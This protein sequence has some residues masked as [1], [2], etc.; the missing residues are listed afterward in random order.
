[1]SLT[2]IRP[3]QGPVNR[4]GLLLLLMAL[5]GTAGAHRLDAAGDFDTANAP[6]VILILTDDQGY[7][8]MSCHGNPWLETP[9]IDRLCAQSVRLEDYHVDPV[10][11]PTRA[12]LMTGRYCTRV[13]AW[14]VTQ[15]RQML[16]PDEVTMAQVFAASGY[17]TG[18]FGK[19]H[20]GDEYPF[21]PRFR[22][23]QDVVC[24][25]AGGPDEI[26]NPATNDFFDDTYLKNGVAKKFNGYCTDVW[27]DET[28][29]FIN[30]R[31]EKQA[32]SE[33]PFFIY[34]PTNAMHGPHHVDEKYSD[35]FT[36]A[37]HGETRA[38][39][40]GQI[41]NFDENLGRLLDR[42]HDDGLERDTI[43]IFMSDNGTGGG[44]N[45]K[46]GDGYNAA[47]RG[48]KGTVYEG[49]HRVPCFVR[50]PATLPSGRAVHQLTCH[51]DWMPTLI[52]LCGLKAPRDVKF[53]GQSMAALLRGSAQENELEESWQQRTVFIERQSDQIRP[54]ALEPL[55]RKRKVPF[56]VLTP[57]WRMVGN[58]LYDAVN[59]PSQDKDVAAKHPEVVSQL[60][61]AY[62]EHYDD[63]ME[64]GGS[65][66][67]FPVDISAKR[68]TLLTVRDWHPLVGR[69]I[70]R[71]QQL[72]DESLLINGW[73]PVE[74]TQGGRFEIRL[75][76][77]PRDAGKPIFADVARLKIGAIEMETNLTSN[78]EHATFEVEL[79]AGDA[80]LQTWFTD[81]NTGNSRGA[82]FVEITPRP[83]HDN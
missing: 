61:D 6:N 25:R 31:T 55:G 35:P 75:S 33:K 10:C 29:R 19:W 78:Q 52:E 43:V 57:K 32:D 38:K 59:D 68:P 48:R 18:M 16:A 27:F 12:A 5:C 15:G 2:N 44:F 7:G 81:T 82:Y 14:S 54:A 50:W 4:S 77:H 56:A 62:R 53:D 30:T 72:S 67:R 13:G 63:V 9:N 1:M 80:R 34:L 70:W 41:I 71:Q 65:E 46:P 22:G 64:H 49:G 83:S 26:G 47:M 36:A 69:V 23:F 74:V 8:D 73:W 66:V 20:L 21:A 51:R 45:G 24:H 76:R 60:Y 58:E 42:L 37:G 17:R 11:T 40:F 3:R 39:F 79:P 28:L